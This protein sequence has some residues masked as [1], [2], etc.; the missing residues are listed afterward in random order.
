M[1]QNPTSNLLFKDTAT[2][3]SKEHLFHFKQT[4]IT[5]LSVKQQ[6]CFIL[7]PLLILQIKKVYMTWS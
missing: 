4:L 5:I 3:Q 1:D 7:F 6:I 2:V